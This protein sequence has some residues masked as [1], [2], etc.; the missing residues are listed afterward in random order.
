MKGLRYL[1]ILPALLLLASISMGVNNYQEAKEDMRQDLTHALRQFVISQSQRQMLMDSM[2]LLHHD[3]VLTL[4]DLEESFNNQLTILSLRDT[5]HISICLARH[6]KMDTFKEKALLCSDTLLWA[7][8]QKGADDAIFALKAYANP[9]LCSI[10]GHS[11][12]RIPITGIISCLLLLSCMAW[13]DRTTHH[14]SHQSA[15]AATPSPMEIHLTPMQEQLMDMF[16]AAPNHTLS[17]TAI[18]SALW[19]KKDNPEC[20]LY[21]FISRL[22]TTLKGQSDMDIINK[23][24]REYQL[25]KKSETN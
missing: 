3:R 4:N 13:K 1:T 22:K 23:R 14:G 18:C 12:Q 25:V 5:S 15:I 10:F 24:G 2:P 6:Q 19:P 8:T 16:A 7:P 17:K 21:T 9:S 11:D 20:T